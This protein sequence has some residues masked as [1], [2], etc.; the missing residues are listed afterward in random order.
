MAGGVDQVQ[1]VDLAVLSLVLQGRSLGLDGDAALFLDVHR[2]KHLRLHV[3]RSKAAAALDQTVR[4]RG[5]AM[6]NV[7]NDGKITD[8]VHQRERQLGIEKQ[9]SAETRKGRDPQRRALN[10]QSLAT[11]IVGTS[12]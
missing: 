8:V 4:Q 2:V 1:V 3:T 12:L 9:W 7:R 5:L 11:A 6:V 10:Q